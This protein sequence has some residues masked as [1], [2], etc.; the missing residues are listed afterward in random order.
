MRVLVTGS[1]GMLGAALRESCPSG[2]QMLDADLPGTD[3]TDPASVQAAFAAAR[4]EAVI[5]AAA[6]TNVD[7]CESHEEQAL[8]VNGAGAGHVAQAC[9]RAGVPLL[10]VSTDYVFDGCI[11]APGEY[12][13][14]DPVGPLSAYGRTKLAGERAVAAAWERHW[15]VRSQWLY[16]LGGRNFVD[17]MLALAAEKPFLAV[18]DDQ[19]GSPT[20]THDLAP[21]LWRFVQ[22]RPP[23]GVWHA[24]AAG[25]TSWHGFAAEIFRQAGLS[26]DLRRQSSAE[27]RR[28]APRPARSVLSNARLTGFFGS[29]LPAWAVGL[30]GYLERRRRWLAEGHA[31]RDTAADAAR[32]RKT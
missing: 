24:S 10:H 32:G 29:G 6:Y 14:A 3:I 13:E 11:P 27:L 19:V 22:R 4:P 12:S 9:A 17:T 23:W 15:I 21:A 7:A 31:P 28:P 2:V 26:V 5:H 18:V 20:C 30:A 16:G 25:S 8:A 1:A